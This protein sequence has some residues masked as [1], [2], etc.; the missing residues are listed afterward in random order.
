MSNPTRSRA[1]RRAKIALRMGLAGHR[2]EPVKAE[3]LPVDAEPDGVP[4]EAAFPSSALR[5]N[6][7]SEAG[8]RRRP[9]KSP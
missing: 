9:K 5:A 7:I 2:I 6:E 8:G 1:V 3:N 4:P